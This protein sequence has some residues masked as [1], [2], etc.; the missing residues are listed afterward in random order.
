MRSKS[1]LSLFR[2]SD[3]GFRSSFL[4]TCPASS[5]TSLVDLPMPALRL[6]TPAFVEILLAPPRPSLQHLSLVVFSAASLAPSSTP[7]LPSLRPGSRRQDPFKNV[8]SHLPTVIN[9]EA[10]LPPARR[11]KAGPLQKHLGSQPR[12]GQRQTFDPPLSYT[13]LEDTNT[14]HTLYI[15]GPQIDVFGFCV[16]PNQGEKVALRAEIEP[17]R[18]ATRSWVVGFP[19]GYK[20][21][22]D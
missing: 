10:T 15:S 6:S 21:G 20:P 5:C 16:L 1:H 19:H 17:D 7:G 4:C 22:W 9:A 14:H 18:P 8:S 13:L 3:V 2:D 11:P 12:G